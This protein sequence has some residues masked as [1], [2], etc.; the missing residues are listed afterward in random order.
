ML[1]YHF[2]KHFYKEGMNLRQVCDW[3]R[4]LWVNRSEIDVAL[5]EKRIRKAG[6]MNEWKSFAALAVDSLDMPVDA[7][8]LYDGS[9]CWHNKGEKLLNFILKGRKPNKVRDTMFFLG[10]FPRNTLSFLPS[11]FFNVNRLKIKE[12]LVG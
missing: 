7:M 3:C 6:L 4:L 1:G 8:P 9:E 12:H 10:L 5:L 2:I 11:I